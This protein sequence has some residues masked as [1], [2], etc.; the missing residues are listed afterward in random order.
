MNPVRIKGDFSS[1]TSPHVQCSVHYIL[2][3]TTK[4]LGLN[5]AG[6]AHPEWSLARFSQEHLDIGKAAH[7]QRQMETD[8]VP[9]IGPERAHNAA[10]CSVCVLVRA[11]TVQCPSPD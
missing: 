6:T 4:L 2:K 7:C 8:R 3:T 1:I 10:V 5:R 11:E 9:E